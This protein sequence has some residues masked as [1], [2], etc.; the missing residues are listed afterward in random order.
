MTTTG[1]VR[2]SFPAW[3]VFVFGVEVTD[4]VISC[5]VNWH[6]GR[7]PGTAEFVLA[8]ELDRYVVTPRDIHAMYDD[9]PAEALSPGPI[10]EREV[11]E[12]INQ[13]IERVVLDPIKRSVLKKKVLER[14][15]DRTQPPLSSSFLVS[16]AE[17]LAG[18][19]VK[20]TF[21]HGEILRFPFTVGQTVFHTGDACRIFW[22]DPFAPT[23]WYFA[24]TGTISDWKEAGDANGRR[25]VTLTVEDAVRPLRMARVALNPAIYDPQA[26]L[27]PAF[28][29]A[30]RNW[31]VDL[32]YDKTFAEMMRI[33]LFGAEPRADSKD[34]LRPPIPLNQFRYGVLDKTPITDV[35][36]K[37]V[38]YFNK[39]ESKLFVYGPE[40][41]GTSQGVGAQYEP[42]GSNS[43][44]R[45]QAAIDHQ[46]VLNVD[47][48]LTLCIPEK[49]KKAKAILNQLVN[50]G[51]LEGVIT[52]LGTHPEIYPVDF[53][54]LMMLV[55]ASLGP[56]GNLA[57]F[58]RDIRN[59]VADQTETMTRLQIIYN[60]CQRLNFSFYAT[61]RGDLVCEMPLS[62]FRPESFGKYADRYRFPVDDTIS[63]E[64]HFEHDKVRTIMLADYAILPGLADIGYASQIWRQPSADT[65]PALV[66]QFGLVAERAEPWAFNNSDEAAKYYASIKLSQMN[67]DA[68]VQTVQ[69]VMHLGVGPNRPCWFEVRDF[70]ATTR[71]V[72]GAIAWGG[73]GGSGS[74][75]QQIK[76][77][78]RRGWSGM[79]DQNNN[80]LYE[81]YGGHMTN[82]LNYAQLFQMKEEEVEASTKELAASRSELSDNEQKQLASNEAF[83]LRQ[84]DIIAEAF[85]D[86]LNVSVDPASIMGSFTRDP[87]HNKRVDGKVDSYHQSGLAIDIPV[88]NLPPGLTPQKAA[89][90]IKGLFSKTP[91]GIAQGD[92]I[93]ERGSDVDDKNPDHIHYEVTPTALYR[94]IDWSKRK[95]GKQ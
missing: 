30:I 48:L 90:I 29:D 67:A 47:D 86:Y 61:P 75:T 73:A 89:Q 9:I 42:L 94:V 7:S 21:L 79:L 17:A 55:P 51:D 10:K 82:P 69:T 70:I 43:L 72:G 16:A 36:V 84:R 63:F 64:S 56:G 87:H 5:N 66:S 38:G 14:I 11:T 54:R 57:V 1:Q 65:R 74:V 44:E 59:G 32:F 80:H 34:S 25:T 92:V 76:L 2:Y 19:V 62:D 88:E 24:A 78:Y 12:A 28:D 3:R 58:L 68:W 4:D 22:R 46:V 40:N 20:R 8:S 85:S 33:T 35:N 95:A 18:N 50:V 31:H 39:A 45:W 77:N 49:R 71:S 26:V 60:V 23:V 81:P 93:L 52:E 13:R 91:G 83:M 27:D 15:K 37:A 41:D 6:D 53:G